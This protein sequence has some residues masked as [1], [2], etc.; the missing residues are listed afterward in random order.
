MVLSVLKYTRRK[1]AT[2]PHA[3]TL[4]VAP[5][6][7]VRCS[8]TLQRAPDRR[9]AAAGSKSSPIFQS[10]FCKHD[11]TLQNMVASYKWT[12]P[13]AGFTLPI[14]SKGNA[15]APRAVSS[16]IPDSFVPVVPTNRTAVT[17]TFP[18]NDPRIV[19]VPSCHVVV[20]V[21]FRAD[22][23]VAPCEQVKGDIIVLLYRAHEF[24]TGKW[25]REKGG[26]VSLSY[27]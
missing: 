16:L 14:M 9:I 3:V 21:C 1:K 2:R 5:L 19:A 10:R 4:K 17:F 8:R 20:S 24:G 22:S 25:N 15:C 12:F 6:G 13:L 26:R 18:G 27:V 7:R 11:L 23:L